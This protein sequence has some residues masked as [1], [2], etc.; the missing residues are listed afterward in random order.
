[1]RVPWTHLIST[2]KEQGIAQKKLGFPNLDDPNHLAYL[3]YLLKESRQEQDLAI[4]LDQLDVIV[5]DFETTGFYPQRGD[6]IISIGAIRFRGLGD[7]E[8]F[9]YTLV[10]PNKAIPPHI[11]ELTGINQDAVS[12]APT[13]KMAIH[14]FM[15]FAGSRVMVA[16][17]A[18][19]DKRFLDENLWRLY[20][21]KVQNRLFDTK[22]LYQFLYPEWE[23]YTLESIL[24]HLN[25]EVGKRHHALSDAQMA[26]DLWRVALLEVLNRGARNLGDLYHLLAAA[27]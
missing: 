14:E 20:R 6:E 8:E 17:Y 23:D 7:E 11:Q 26:A 9:F 2:I 3:R 22:N 15:K 5:F 27:R 16:H 1:M 12:T 24:S 18:N 21:L 25:R 10:K 19:H 4:P 13:I